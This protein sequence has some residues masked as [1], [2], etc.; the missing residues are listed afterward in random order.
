MTTAF[1]R[2]NAAVIRSRGHAVT[3]GNL[4][5][6]HF[7]GVGGSIKALSANR[8]SQVADVFGAHMVRANPFLRGKTIDHLINWA[9]KKM[10]GKAPKRPIA[11]PGQAK[12]AE[13]SIAS[14]NSRKTKAAAKD[15]SASKE[16]K[17]NDKAAAPEADIASAASPPSGELTRYASDPRFAALK[18][19][20]DILMH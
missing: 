17:G 7:L 10:S 12:P 15:K 19:S 8:S 6:A 4:Y 16:A 1:T 13:E 20:V 18:R 11:T 5:L 3:P 14:N 9:A 2:D